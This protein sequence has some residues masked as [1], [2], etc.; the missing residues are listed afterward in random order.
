VKIGL[1]NHLDKVDKKIKIFEKAVDVKKLKLN[2]IGIKKIFL[3]VDAHSEAA[4]INEYALQITLNLAKKHQSEVY[5]ACIAPTSEELKI[6]E[7]LVNKALRLLET[8]NIIVTGS[9]GYGHPSEKILNLSNHIN[10]SLIVLPTPYG[11]RAEKF[12]IESLGTSV[13]LILRK[14]PFP[15]LLVRKPI[16]PPNEIMN[17][18]LLIIDSNKTIKAAE[19]A[20]TMTQDNSNIMLLSITEKETVEKVEE[21]AESLLDS[22]IDKD[23]VEHIHQKENQDLI[24]G[25]ISEAKTK[26]VQIEKELLIGDK[27]RLILNEAKENY[28]IL[29][30]A[31][32]LEQDNVFEN[33]VE[34]ICR[35]VQ[36][37]I[38]II[39]D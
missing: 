5:I 3:A 4:D 11:E 35:L 1:S 27:I 7:K 22:E 33:E 13:D 32:A 26:G 12:N 36:I 10:P 37:P 30:L 14:S 39:K 34:N 21:L 6:S 16:F 15:T 2:L 24:N 28:T 8:E 19:W 23:L 20:L 29:I 38:L 31:T 9:C 25:I 18:I 17:K